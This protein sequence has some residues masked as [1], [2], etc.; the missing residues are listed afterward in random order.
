MFEE[1]RK[2]TDS[3][4]SDYEIPGNDCIIY[5]DGKE[6]YRHF[7]GYS[8][9]ENRIPMN[10]KEVYNIYSCSKPI[11]ATAGMQLVEK[12]VIRLEDPLYE[13][14]PEYRNM[15]VH[16]GGELVPDPA[17]PKR[18][19]RVGGEFVP[20]KNVI[21]IKDL[22]CMT[23]GF[24]YDTDAKCFKEL[25]EKTDGRCPTVEAAKALAKEPLL[26]EPGEHWEYSLCLDVL[27][28]VIEIASGKRFGEYVRE[29]IFE[30]LGMKD[31]TFLLPAEKLDTVCAQY[32]CDI[33]TRERKNCGKEI[34]N[35]DCRCW[36]YKI[37]SEYESGGAGCIST[38]EDYVKFM[39]ALR[40]GGVLL[41]QE[42]T[43]LMCT[44]MLNAEQKKT[45]WQ[46][47]YSYGLGVRVP[48]PAQGTTDFGW[49][50][51]AGAYM[52]IDRVNGIMLYYA[53]HVLFS[54]IL[55]MR[56]EVFNAARRAIIG[57]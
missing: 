9:I 10:G 20:A 19:T 48:D 2:L 24:S 31:S 1:V 28:A 34:R 5:K 14:I 33:F 41:S 56:A 55:D 6:V 46:T 45:F 11:T 16:T 22:F 30:P 57:R 12:G 27:A 44:D 42:T 49:S 17:F 36:P 51:A 15:Y 3:F 13:Y 4:I 23:A 18:V 7:A 21:T 38:V 32:Q 52:A 50:G 29:N 47:G 26:F 43:D 53:Q 39:E 25:W 54:K 35:V 8:D 40:K 37:G